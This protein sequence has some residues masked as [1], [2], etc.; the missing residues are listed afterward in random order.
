MGGGGERKYTGASPF[1]LRCKQSLWMKKERSS[2]GG[3]SD[4]Q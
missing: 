2:L 4:V 3:V 1:P